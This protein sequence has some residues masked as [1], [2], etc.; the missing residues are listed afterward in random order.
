MR[1]QYILAPCRIQTTNAQA[2]E[3]RSMPSSRLYF[4]VPPIAASLFRFMVVLA[5]IVA[6]SGARDVGG[7]HRG[8]A[9]GGVRAH[10]DSNAL[11]GR[12]DPSRYQDL[13][14]RNVGPHRGGRVTA[15]SGVRTQ[16]SV[17]YM[18]ATGGGVW[19]TQ[20][21]GITWAPI[22]DGQIATGS[23]GAIAVAD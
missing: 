6:A 13:K 2:D 19:K 9:Q 11:D 4:Y 17:F 16:P 1:C 18:G 22:T 15:V 12:G 21:Y 5:V 8:H 14:W 10:A 7:G 20:D 3:M 23:I